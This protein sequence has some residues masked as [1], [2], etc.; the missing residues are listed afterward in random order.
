MRYQDNPLIRAKYNCKKWKETRKLV[1]QRANGLC[2]RCLKKKIYNE[3]KIVHHIIEIN[4]DNYMDDSIMYN[5][6]NLEFVCDTC[7]KRRA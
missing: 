4:E 7:H 2:E 5:I 3:G 6:D 1:I